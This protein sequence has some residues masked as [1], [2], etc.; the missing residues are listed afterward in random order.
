MIPYYFLSEQRTDNAIVLCK[1]RFL[2]SFKVLRVGFIGMA[3]NG[4]GGMEWDE[5]E[6]DWT[7]SVADTLGGRWPPNILEDK[8]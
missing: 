7:G 3:W 8:Q 5:M 1:G 2:F 4:I 6:L